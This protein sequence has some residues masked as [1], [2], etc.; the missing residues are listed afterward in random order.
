MANVI[1]NLMGRQNKPPHLS[2]PEIL[3]R[4]ESAEAELI[5]ADGALAQ[6]AL[7]ALNG[8]PAANAKY[9]DAKKL[10]ADLHEKVAIF[11]KAHAAAI[12]NDQAQLESQRAGIRKA[13]RLAQRRHLDAVGKAVDAFCVA[14]AEAVRQYH[15]AVEHAGK[16][17][18]ATPI[19]ANFPEGTC[20]TPTMLKREVGAELVRLSSPGLNL[21]GDPVLLFPGMDGFCPAGFEDQ[22]GNIEPLADRVRRD[23]GVV[24]DRIGATF[25]EPAK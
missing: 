24:L 20:I 9:Q 5:E 3:R 16:A 8:D 2:A 18:A 22:P 12:A 21:G 23:I 6:A 13:Q 10:V 7:E 15:L 25:K 11:T 14:Q 19:G 17:I 4:R 1:D